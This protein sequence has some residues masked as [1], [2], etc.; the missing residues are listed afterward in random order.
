MLPDAD[1][2]TGHSATCDSQTRLLPLSLT[3]SETLSLEVNGTNRR[4]TQIPPQ[5]FPFPL[6]LFSHLFLLSSHISGP[7][8]L[9]LP[10]IIFQPSPP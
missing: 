4:R 5:A 7:L 2:A 10:L 8:L 3:G 6:F 9:V 1:R